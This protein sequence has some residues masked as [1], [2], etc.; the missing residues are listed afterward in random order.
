[1]LVVPEDIT[2]SMPQG[3]FMLHH[4]DMWHNYTH[5]QAVTLAQ[6]HFAVFSA[7]GK[8]PN[9]NGKVASYN[10]CMIQANKVHYFSTLFEYTADLLSI[11]RSL[12]TVFT[13]DCQHKCYDKYIKYTTMC[14][15]NTTNLYYVLYC[16]RAT[17]FDSYR[18][19]F[20]P[21]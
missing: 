9:E 14:Q 8:L 12:D 6:L 5:K 1:M 15:S 17:Y 19:I 11:I 18:I 10:I 20:R 16:I 4:K 2:R 7:D 13:A 21:F 3:S